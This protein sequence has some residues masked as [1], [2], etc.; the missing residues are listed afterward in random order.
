MRFTSQMASLP[1]KQEPEQRLA[2]PLD[3]DEL[4]CLYDRLDSEAPEAPMDS[5]KDNL[6]L[7]ELLESEPKANSFLE[8]VKKYDQLLKLLQSTANGEY[9]V[10]VPVDAGWTENDKNQCD[11]AMV[12]MHISPHYFSTAALKDCPN[13][14]TLLRTGVSKR[15]PVLQS[16]FGPSGWW[17][18]CYNKIIKSNMMA[19]NGIAHFIQ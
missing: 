8:Q 11:E 15:K 13:L 3:L 5:S 9:T 18:N 16:T 4:E 19:Q 1:P 12:A 14:P 7:L 10:F 2:L 17:I 6:S